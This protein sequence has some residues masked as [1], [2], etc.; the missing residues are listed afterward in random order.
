MKQKTTFAALKLTILTL[1]T[2]RATLNTTVTISQAPYMLLL[3][4]VFHPH[5]LGN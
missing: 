1:I 3:L 2:M 4:V 5:T